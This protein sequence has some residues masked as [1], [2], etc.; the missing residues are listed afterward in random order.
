M[1]N[2][3]D[4]TPQRKISDWLRPFLKNAQQR[5]LLI[6]NLRNIELSLDTGN[7][8][9]R[10]CRIIAVLLSL[11]DER[12]FHLPP[13]DIRRITILINAVIKEEGLHCT[14]VNFFDRVYN[15]NISSKHVE[16]ANAILLEYVCSLQSSGDFQQMFLCNEDGRIERFR[17]F[18][19]FMET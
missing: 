18:Q 17:R 5:T 10:L 8:G 2:T 6:W 15:T 13:L 1:E 9:T 19:Y 14:A 11:I 3:G 7:N 12:R 16:N 4:I